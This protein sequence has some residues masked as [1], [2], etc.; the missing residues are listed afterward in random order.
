MAYVVALT[1]LGH[2]VVVLADVYANR[3]FDRE[4]KPVG[5][6]DFEGR[7]DFERLA[8]AYGVDFDHCL[9]YD[10]GAAT[11]GM[12]LDEAVAHAESADV[13]INIGG[14][15]QTSVVVDPIP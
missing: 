5:F 2:E 11:D 8:K 7:R 4:Y 15:L 1:E 3:C 6:H 14:K 12:S 13:L 9:I 10:G